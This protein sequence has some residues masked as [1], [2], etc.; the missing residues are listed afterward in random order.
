MVL[1]EKKDTSGLSNANAQNS[2]F[3]HI[4]LLCQSL[5]GKGL[6]ITHVRAFL[7]DLNR[8]D[9]TWSSNTETAYSTPY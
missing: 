5:L 6:C 7:S 4:G 3:T 1:I 8:Q 2:I 9:F